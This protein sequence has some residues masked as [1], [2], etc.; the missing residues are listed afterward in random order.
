MIKFRLVKNS[1]VSVGEER[2]TENIFLNFW[3]YFTALFYTFFIKCK[4][5][6]PFL[7]DFELMYF[8]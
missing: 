3:I 7:G 8:L 2:L 6:K 4:N 5:A 1:K